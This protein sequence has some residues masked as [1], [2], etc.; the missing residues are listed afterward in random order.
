MSMSI[1]SMENKQREVEY[2]NQRISDLQDQWVDTHATYSKARKDGDL[3][4]RA[5]AIEQMAMTRS[6]WLAHT[7]LI[8]EIQR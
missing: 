8:A 6:I 7:A 2:R 4:S 5:L 3:E 1:D